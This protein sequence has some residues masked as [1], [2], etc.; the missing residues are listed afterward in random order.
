MI[1]IILLFLPIGFF[2]YL[3]FLIVQSSLF[4]DPTSITKSLIQTGN[5]HVAR[6]ILIALLF[7]SYGMY[8]YFKKTHTSFRYIFGHS[9]TETVILLASSYFLSTFLV[10]SLIALPFMHLWLSLIATGGMYILCGNLLEY[11]SNM[12]VYKAWRTIHDFLRVDIYKATITALNFFRDIGK[13]YTIKAI[14]D[15]SKHFFHKGKKFTAFLGAFLIIIFIGVQYFLIL[16]N[17]Y[18]NTLKS[19]LFITDVTPQTTTLGITQKVK[20][21]N[22]GWMLD[23][24]DRLMSEY[25]PIDIQLWTN[26]QITFIVPLHWKEGK[27]NLWITKY[28]ADK[29]PDVKKISNKVL[30]T[31]ESRWSYFPTKEELQ[32]KTL[33]SYFTRTIKKLKRT[34]LLPTPHFSQ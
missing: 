15:N 30:L 10:K 29:N 21:Y 33:L 23:S 5:S 25:G 16:N 2:I 11:W 27:V 8:L 24:R 22:F 28:E 6:M 7:A 13:K 34:Y 17:Q 14:F 26:E 18:E 19:R 4:P 20:G 9:K 32:S 3:A 31:V 1:A 12:E